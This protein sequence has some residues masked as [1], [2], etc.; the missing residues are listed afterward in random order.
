MN[1]TYD[2]AFG[3]MRTNLK[4]IMVKDFQDRF[5]DYFTSPLAYS[6]GREQMNE[7]ALLEESFLNVSV[8]NEIEDPQAPVLTEENKAAALSWRL[9]D[10]P[11]ESDKEER[12]AQLVVVNVKLKDFTIGGFKLKLLDALKQFHQEFTKDLI[13]LAIEREPKPTGGTD[14]SRARSKNLFEVLQQI[15]FD[16][17]LKL[18]MFYFRIFKNIIGRQASLTNQILGQLFNLYDKKLD[19][20]KLPEFDK[21]THAYLTDLTEDLLSIVVMPFRF[22]SERFADFMNKKK[23]DDLNIANFQ[24]LVTFFQTVTTFAEN[25]VV[26][27]M[28]FRNTTKIRNKEAFIRLINKVQA[29]TEKIQ[30]NTVV[31]LKLEIERSFI[32]SYHKSKLANLKQNL[33]LENWQ[34]TDIPYS[35]LHIFKFLNQ[36]SDE[37]QG[38]Y[39]NLDKT[40]EMLCSSRGSI[41]LAEEKESDDNRENTE[42]EERKMEISD[43]KHEDEE[44]KTEEKEKP[45]EKPREKIP[46]P[47]DITILKNEIYI[48]KRRYKLTSAFLLLMKVIYD[49]MHIAEN[50]PSISVDATNR[51]VEIVRFYNSYTCQLI[52]SA[53]AIHFQ[54]IKTITAKILAM[55][56][57]GISLLSGQL[58]NVKLRLQSKLQGVNSEW[59]EKEFAKVGQDLKNHDTEIHS[60]IIQILNERLVSNSK[61]LRTLEWG[62]QREKINIPTKSTAQNLSNTCLLYTSPSPRDRQKSR[63]PSSA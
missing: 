13:E 27:L 51:I 44:E 34:P 28:S 35:Y 45:E 40:E 38:Q 20:E 2:S 39:E 58:E 60:K 3:E 25:E 18:M 56:S 59:M 29:A 31:S 9:N 54:Q 17:F 16:L 8:L 46:V 26:A 36:K 55:S 19:E 23:L 4:K 7:T 24:K 5:L 42:E 33:E 1:R 62:N 47:E 37:P 43:E 30:A 11:V 48:N 49:Y 52:L 53:G 21:A 15:N 14:E 50:F 63:M 12:I 6:K 10:S 32:T 61:V 57:L 41:K 22:F